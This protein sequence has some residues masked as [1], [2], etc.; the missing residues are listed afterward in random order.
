MSCVDKYEVIQA[1]SRVLV[2]IYLVGEFATRWGCR[3]WP[4]SE[5][6][7]R[8]RS[9]S[10]QPTHPRDAAALPEIMV[11]NA[12]QLITLTEPGKGTWGGGAM[13]D[14]GDAVSTVTSFPRFVLA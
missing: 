8:V 13:S 9:T 5:D 12:S 1:A 3:K 11:W 2:R 4:S 10:N 14:S 6:V 7:N